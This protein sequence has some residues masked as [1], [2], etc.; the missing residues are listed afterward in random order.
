[1][2]G[3]G[4]AE[5]MIVGVVALIV[6]GPK[7]LPVMFRKLGNFVGKA[8]GMARDFSRAMNDAADSA[9]LKDTM[10]SVNSLKDSVDSVK[11]PTKAWTSYVP[12]SETEKL[13]Q[14]KE[15]RKASLQDGVK[16]RAAELKDQKA[17]AEAEAAAAQADAPSDPAPKP[18]KAKAPKAKKTPA[19]KKPAQTASKGTDE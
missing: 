5:M 4:W 3:M 17:A 6:V 19:K 13:A 2:F 8:R 14:E 9:G 1:M 10:D 16:K 15:A 7:E 12:G 18:A 11:S